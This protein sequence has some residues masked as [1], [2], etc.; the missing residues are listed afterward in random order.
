MAIEL[1]IWL[2]LYALAAFRIAEL[3]VIDDGPWD[4]FM[5]LRGLH[6]RIPFD[7]SLRR[8]F[9]NVL[10][11]V[12]CTGIWV[13]FFLTFTLPYKN[14]TEFFIYFLSIAGLQS[15]LAGNLGRGRK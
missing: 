11:C 4:V 2:M 5:Y 6:T 8:Q 14:V 3:L 13:S 12:H 15:L 9:I 1:F 10:M 7:N